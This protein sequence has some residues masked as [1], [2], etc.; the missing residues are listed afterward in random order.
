MTSTNVNIKRSPIRWFLPGSILAIATFLIA[1]FAIYY[2]NDSILADTNRQIFSL[3]AGAIS[4]TYLA[5]CYLMGSKA[6]KQ[7]ENS[8]SIL[9]KSTATFLMSL[10]LISIA[11]AFTM[12]FILH[13]KNWLGLLAI[14]YLTI[15]GFM[16]TK[17]FYKILQAPRPCLYCTKVA[18]QFLR[19]LIVI[20][21][22][23]MCAIA[24][25][26]APGIIA[27]VT[28]MVV[29]PAISIIEAKH[30]K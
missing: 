4:I 17:Y 26:L 20:N 10:I 11:F 14:A 24:S 9:L 8:E 23:M 21:L 19:S 5:T 27:F 22:A 18:E 7:A 13:P 2:F 25:G 6:L 30:F 16:R 3:A 15:W 1:A 12:H 28:V 29:Y